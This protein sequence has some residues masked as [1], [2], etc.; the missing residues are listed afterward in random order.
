MIS[1]N[2]LDKYSQNLE[3][4]LSQFYD[5]NEKVQLFY[6]FLIC[7]YCCIVQLICFLRCLIMCGASVQTI[8][9]FFLESSYWVKWWIDPLLPS[10]LSWKRQQTKS[11]LNIMQKPPRKCFSIHFS[12]VKNRFFVIVNIETKV[13]SDSEFGGHLYFFGIRFDLYFKFW[14][15][16]HFIFTGFFKT[17][18]SF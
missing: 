13:K 17:T 4:P 3:F 16:Q 2:I 18:H 12:F 1:D 9:H 15:L 10:E 8:I 5:G 7:F 11:L 6:L 14:L